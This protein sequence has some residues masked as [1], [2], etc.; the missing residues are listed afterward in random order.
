M[1]NI[2]FKLPPL[3]QWQAEWVIIARLIE[4]HK[5]FTNYGLRPEHFTDPIM[6]ADLRVVAAPSCGRFADHARRS[7]A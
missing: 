7:R 6:P 3:N 1:T 4:G 5:P 2:N